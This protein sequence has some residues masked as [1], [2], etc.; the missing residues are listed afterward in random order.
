MCECVG[1]G[2]EVTRCEG[3]NDVHHSKRYH[4][5]VPVYVVVLEHRKTPPHCYSFLH[6]THEFDLI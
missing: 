6:F 1:T 5:F 2:C 4:L 3:T